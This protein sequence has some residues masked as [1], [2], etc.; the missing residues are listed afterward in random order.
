MGSPAPPDDLDRGASPVVVR[1]VLDLVAEAKRERDRSTW[2]PSILESRAAVVRREKE[3]QAAR[4]RPQAA[5]PLGPSAADAEYF[6]K[7]A[8]P[9]PPS[10]AT[11]AERRTAFE[12]GGPLIS[13]ETFEFTR[14]RPHALADRGLVKTPIPRID[15]SDY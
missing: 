12:A 6:R 9:L 2:P 3:E 15:P 10:P 7:T 4:A 5:Y 11:L 14:P 13:N 1:F 8:K